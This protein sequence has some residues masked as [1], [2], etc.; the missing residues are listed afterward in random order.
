VANVGS[1]CEAWS[2]QL[3]LLSR[4]FRLLIKKSWSILLLDLIFCGNQFQLAFSGLISS[5]QLGVFSCM[6]I[7][8]FWLVILKLINWSMLVFWV[9]DGICSYLF[10]VWLNIGDARSHLE[11][12]WLLCYH[13]CFWKLCFMPIVDCLY[14]FYQRTLLCFVS[15]AVSRKIYHLIGSEDSNVHELWKQ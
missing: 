7:W 8:I 5:V 14:Q 3:C 15:L 12:C 10:F 1:F 11:L 6:H 9:L 13:V 4:L 2:H